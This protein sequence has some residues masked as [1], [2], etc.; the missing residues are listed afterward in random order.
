VA[1]V[2]VAVVNQVLMDL[3]RPLT[4][5][6]M[7]VLDLPAGAVLLPIPVV[8]AAVVALAQVTS[9]VLLAVRAVRAL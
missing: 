9:V 8:V 5:E 6:Q 1:V 7:A 2:L 3:V 4:V